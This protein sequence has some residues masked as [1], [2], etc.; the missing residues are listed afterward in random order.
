MTE[1]SLDDLDAIAPPVNDFRRTGRWGVPLVR[2]VESTKYERY[3]RPSSVGKILDDESALTDWKIRTIV[4]GAAQRPDLMASVSVLDQEADKA[5]IRDIAESCLE[6]GKGTQ[7]R[8]T[9]TAIHAMLDRIDRDEDWTPAPQFATACQAYVTMKE[10]YGLEVVDIECHCVNDE[11]RLAGTMDRRYR[12]TRPMVAPDG[13]TIPV[14][15]VIAGD[16]KTGSKLEYAKGSY[17]T[18]LAAYADSVRYDVQTDVRIPFNP[19]TYHE[20]AVIVHLEPDATR[21]DLYFVDLEAG[22]HG[23][24]LSNHVYE[25]RRR[26]DLLAPARAALRV[27]PVDPPAPTEQETPITALN[28]V[29]GEGPSPVAL[30]D[31]RE[32]LRGRLR[33]ISAIPDAL[34]HLQRVWPRGVAGLKFATQTEDDLNAIADACSEVER[35]YAMGF[36]EI[37][38]RKRSEPRERNEPPQWGSV[39]DLARNIQTH[40]RRT[41]LE[42]WSAIGIARLDNSITDRTGVTH[43]LY[44]FALLEG[45]DEDVSELLDGTLRAIG[46]DD[47]INDLGRVRPDDAPLVM[48]AAFALAAGNALLLYDDN[49][50]PVVRT[51]TNQP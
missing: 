47:G 9:G 4:A 31:V 43:A 45:E 46:Y 5:A 48:S 1:F 23:L 21:C 28:G 15:E 39:D 49:G 26:S 24:A 8:N 2:G 37:D 20:W 22:R 13:T 14:G 42:R 50:R 17:A 40:P 18:Q 33:A 34:A 6:A 38:P 41:L 30:S 19:P 29:T 32:W 11:Y 7:R 51:I 10:A 12:L 25:W 3:R 36:P 35:A 44:E 27:V 16:T